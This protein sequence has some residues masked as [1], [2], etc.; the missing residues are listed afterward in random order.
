VRNAYAPLFEAHIQRPEISA[1]I[2]A[3]NPYVGMHLPFKP[4][5]SDELICANPLA[6]QVMEAAMGDIVCTFYHSNTTLTGTDIQPIHIDMPSL[7]FPGL[8]VALPPWLMVVNIPLIDF[9]LENGS[10]E[11]WPG[12]HLDPDDTNLAERCAARPSVRTNVYVGDLVVRDMRVWHRGMPNQTTAIRTMLAVVYHRPW[13]HNP[14]YLQVP[15]ASL[16]GLSE[17][18]QQIFAPNVMVD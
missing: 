3:G 18:A 6:V 15:R 14:P 8:P 13:F 1:K 11:V 17:H 2:D 4:P 9:T 5:F 16:Q 7:L 10:T 12:T